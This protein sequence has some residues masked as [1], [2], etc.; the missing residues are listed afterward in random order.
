MNKRELV[1]A[2]AAKTDFTRKKIDRAIDAIVEAVS[3]AMK[4]GESVALLGFGTFNVTNRSARS[5]VNPRTR[6]MIHIAARRV[7]G[8]HA[9]KALKELVSS[10]HSA[11][12][13]Y[14]GTTDG[15]TSLCGQGITVFDG[16][17]RF[18]NPGDENRVVFG[19]PSLTDCVVHVTATLAS[20]SGYGIYYRADGKPGFQPGIT[21]YCFQ[22]DPGLSQLL[23]RKV[24][25]GYESEPFQS[26]PMPS[27]VATALNSLHD[28]SVAVQGDHHVI[29]VDGAV[30]LEFHDG[31]FSSGMA[32]LRG[33]NGCDASFSAIS[34]IPNP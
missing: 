33:W 14:D 9:G 10:I 27:S 16:R 20:G 2:V 1:D 21:G 28:I 24:V 4:N 11:A 26:I 15:I 32:G 19:V 7:P 5:G 13:V 3:E 29:S 34:V 12:F 30:V 17:L 8:F 18:T 6:E 23:V 31:S 25:D 22:F